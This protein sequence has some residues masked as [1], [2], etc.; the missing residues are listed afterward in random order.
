MTMPTSHAALGD[1]SRMPTLRDLIGPLFRYHRASAFTFLLIMAATVTAAALATRTYEAQM[2]ILVNRERMDPI[3]SSD[4]QAQPSGRVEVTESELYSEIELLTSRDVLEQVALASGLVD[5]SP[6]SLARDTRDARVARAVRSLAADLDAQ[7]LRKTTM[8]SVAYSSPDPQQAARVLDQLARLYLEKH[9]ALHRPPGARQ[10]FADQAR[11]FQDELRVAEARLSAFTAREHVV[12]ATGEREATLQKLS[13]FESTLQQTEASIADTT[14]R[15]AAIDAEL[16]GT[17]SRQVTQ[18]RDGNTEVIRTLKTQVLQ[19][20]LKRNDMLQKFTPQYPPLVQAEADIRKLQAA[21]ADA[22]QTPL[23]DQT[24]DR[25]P[26]YQWLSSER[27]RVRTERDALV[28]RAEATRRTIAEYRQRASRLDAQ[29]VEQQELIRTVKAAEDNYQLYQRKQEEARISD[30]L[31][32]TR[33]ANV[34]LAEPPAVPQS[35]RSP[36]R[37]ILVVGTSLAFALSLVIA[38]LLQMMN[39]YFSTPDDVYRVLDVPVLASLPA[40]AD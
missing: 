8:I 24:T 7:P 12:S 1:G 4:P 21:I 31:D 25:N 33:I 20:E 27:A 16:A 37:L 2:K 28:A 34:A 9:L 14:R 23:R 19:L 3:V 26:T 13:E 29:S 18:E 30:E 22:E 32:R 17:P 38:Y 39:P 5:E 11:R 40:H 35:A 10:F 36:R 6:A 15:M